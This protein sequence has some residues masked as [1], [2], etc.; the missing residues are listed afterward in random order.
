MRVEQ[1]RVDEDGVEHRLLADEDYLVGPGVH[2]WRHVRHHHRNEAAVFAA[3]VVGDADLDVESAVLRVE[4]VA[5]DGAAE[6]DFVSPGAELDDAGI[7]E[8]D[9]V[10]QQATVVTAQVLE[11]EG[12]RR[13]GADG[14]RALEDGE[15][16][17]RRQRDGLGN[18]VADA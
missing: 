17:V 2:C 18:E 5:E 16:R 13:R 1:A 4:V 6:A 8:Q 10:E 7:G 3:V 15:R 9:V 14:E 12:E 11:A